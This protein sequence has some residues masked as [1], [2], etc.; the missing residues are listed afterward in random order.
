[1]VSIPAASVHSLPLFSF[2]CQKL[3]LRCQQKCISFSLSRLVLN[4]L[5]CLNKV[6]RFSNQDVHIRVR[7]LPALFQLSGVSRGHGG[8]CRRPSG[9]SSLLQ[10]SSP[11]SFAHTPPLQHDLGLLTCTTR[12]EN[13][14]LRRFLEGLCV[15]ILD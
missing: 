14:S 7:L 15:K 2:S 11:D 10:T 1:M 6:C 12:W 4:A 9:R 13:G 8:A 5:K 3:N